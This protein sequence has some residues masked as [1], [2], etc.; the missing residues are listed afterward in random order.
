[1]R[2]LHTSDWHLGRTFHG[3]DLLA[4]QEV[5]LSRIAEIVQEKQ[6]DVV[7]VS[8]DIYDRSA[9]AADAVELC[10]RALLAI[11]RAG[12]EIVLISG[13]HDSPARLGFAAE[14][15]AS[16]GLHLRTKVE[17]IDDPVVFA[18]ANC[19]VAVYGIPYLEPETARH[20]LGDSSLRTHE[21]VLGEAM[22][23]VRADLADRGGCRSLVLAHA[24]VTGAR[25]CESERSIS[26]GGVEDVS[27]DTF[28]GVDYVALGHL[29]GAQEVRPAVRYSGTPMAY[30]FSEARHQK[31]VWLVDISADGLSAVERLPL[32]VPRPLAVLNG[33]LDDLLADP[34]LSHH[35]ASYLSVVLTDPARPLDAMRRLQVRFPY[36]VHLEWMPEGGRADDGA[37]YASRVR[38]R[39][40]LD[41]AVEFIGH[42]RGTDATE[43][44]RELLRKAF[45][46]LRVAE[47]TG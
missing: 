2:F 10:G 27:A 17:R 42:A 44:E 9:P 35:E 40:E 19:E 30:S 11:R 43:D 24:F 45:E 23:R 34:S 7:L 33:R 26:V 15:L 41:V 20:Q 37:S 25:G 29:H 13:N 39:S 1:M 18:D 21:A 46:E 4:D 32:P 12:A 6:V 28:E 47:V 8:G 3:R 31:S 38:G 16:G 22:R 14:L 36:C 5:V